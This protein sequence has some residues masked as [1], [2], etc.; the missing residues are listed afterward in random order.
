MVLNNPSSVLKLDEFIVPAMSPVTIKVLKLELDKLLFFPDVTS[1]SKVLSVPL[2]VK[3]FIFGNIKSNAEIVISN[4]ILFWCFML[5][6]FCLL[7]I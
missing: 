5:A 3:A 2:V 4:L 1:N 7:R 6:I